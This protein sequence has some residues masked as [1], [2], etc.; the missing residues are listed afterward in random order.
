MQWCYIPQCYSGWANGTPQDHDRSLP[1][2]ETLQLSQRLRPAVPR[3]QI[4]K[5]QVIEI[6]MLWMLWLVVLW[7]RWFRSPVSLL[8]L[9]LIRELAHDPGCVARKAAWPRLSWPCVQEKSCLHHTLE[10]VGVGPRGWP[11]RRACL[12]TWGLLAWTSS[13]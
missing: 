4:D 5:T 7:I 3:G 11:C 8:G 10:I 13:W 9:A 6:L 1:Q 12:R 2:K